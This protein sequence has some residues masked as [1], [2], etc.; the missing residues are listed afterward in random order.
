[1]ISPAFSEE[2][3]NDE[4]AWTEES[5]YVKRHLYEKKAVAVYNQLQKLNHE[6]TSLQRAKGKLSIL[7]QSWP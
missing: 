2:D 5:N 7:P 3:V 6:S 4:N 1:M